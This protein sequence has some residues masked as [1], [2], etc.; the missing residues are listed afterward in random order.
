MTLEEK[1]NEL[2]HKYQL[3]LSD[4]FKELILRVSMFD[5]CGKKILTPI[6]TLV[7]FN[8]FLLSD[9]VYEQRDILNWYKTT[10][11]SHPDLL[12]FGFGGSN[13]SYCIKVI[14]ENC[15]SVYLLDGDEDENTERIIKI[16][17]SIT[18]FIKSLR[19]E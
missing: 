16:A 7:E 6:G 2:E 18:E 3:K 12:V 8:N 13:E 15:G 10:R 4:E 17:P 9:D 5:Y 11:H 19:N 1:I 14:G